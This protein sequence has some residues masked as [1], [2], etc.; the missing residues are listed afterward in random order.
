[1]ILWNFS[2]IKDYEKFPGREI[3]NA[4][5]VFQFPIDLREDE[6]KET[7]V[8]CTFTSDGAMYTIG[9]LD[10][11]LADNDTTAFIVIKNDAII[12]EKYFNGYTRDSIN[13]S[14][15]VAKSV[16]SA[17]VGIAID[18]GLIEGVDAPVVNYLPELKGKGLDTL[19][20]RHLLMMSSGLKYVEGDLWW[21]DDPLNYYSPD[22]RRLATEKAIVEEAPGIHFHYNNYHPQYLGM[23]LERVSGISVS[24]YLEKTIWSKIGMEYNASWST[25]SEESELEHMES[26]LNA[27]SIDFAKF[28]RLFLKGGTWEGG[29][30]VS[31]EWV[32]ESTQPESPPTADYYTG[33][34]RWS[35]EVFRDGA[36]G[37]Y[38]YF[39]WGFV[40]PDGTYDYYARG[41][42]GQVI[43][44]C[45][46][47]ELII[48]RNG[49]SGGVAR[50]WGVVCRAIAE[51][52]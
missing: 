45:P 44:I 42:L 28:G 4:P 36:G 50:N 51:R 7:L 16:T 24:S 17:L 33:V 35:D 6:V 34:E 31:E 47:K 27:R 2:D 15:S 1:F 41:H 14:F 9:D 37:Y 39:W 20:I 30:I 22:L 38:K 46:S 49:A 19:T 40:N 29:R 18:E 8:S 10:K 12:Y 32:N 5:A 23:I 48:V 43:Y 52:M 25:D 3:A 26:C 11:F 21:A 13:T